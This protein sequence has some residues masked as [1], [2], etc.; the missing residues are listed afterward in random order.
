[1]SSKIAHAPSTWVHRLRSPWTVAVAT[2]TVLLGPSAAV[3]SALGEANAA[4]HLHR[5]PAFVLPAGT[6][7]GLPTADFL[8]RPF[9]S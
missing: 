6:G 2:A 8:R 9:G 4:P 5:P 7:G 1:M 3:A